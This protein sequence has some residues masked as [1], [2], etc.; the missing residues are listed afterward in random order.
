MMMSVKQSDKGG[1]HGK[2]TRVA[3]MLAGIVAA[4]V[5]A[6]CSAAEQVRSKLRIRVGETAPEIALTASD[7][8]RV[9]LSDFAGRNVLI[10][11]FR[12]HW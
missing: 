5:A 2:C 9:R 10:D 6:E 11:F 4:F 1:I 7:G 3:L 12:A 8:K